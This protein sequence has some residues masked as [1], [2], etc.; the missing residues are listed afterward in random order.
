MLKFLYIRICAKFRGKFTSVSDSLSS[1]VRYP[2]YKYP[3]VEADSRPNFL[4][5]IRE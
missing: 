1:Q 2:L 3:Y 5:W 4:V